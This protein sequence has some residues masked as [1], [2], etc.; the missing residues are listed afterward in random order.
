MNFKFRNKW[1]QVF[2]WGLFNVKE[3]GFWF[4]R[5]WP[6]DGRNFVAFYSWRIGWVEV[7][8]FLKR[9]WPDDDGK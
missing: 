8:L 1:I 9:K 5:K 3:W 2:S 6:D 4:K 7:R